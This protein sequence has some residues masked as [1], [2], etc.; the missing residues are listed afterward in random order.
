MNEDF[1]RPEEIPFQEVLDALQDEDNPIKPRYLYRLTDLGRQ[2]QAKISALWD[3]LP[4]WRRSGLLEDLEFLFEKNTLLSFEAICRLAI[5]DQEAEIRFLA[6][7]SLD[8]YDVPDL[9]DTFIQMMETDPDTDVRAMSA[10]ALGKYV[11][12][13]EVED[14]PAATFHRLEERLLTTQNGQDDDLIRRRALEALGFSSRPEVAERI[15]LAFASQDHDWMQSALFAMGRSYDERW[16][17][18]VLSM[19]TDRMPTIRAE[20]ARAAGEL[21]MS[22]AAQHLIELTDDVDDEVRSAAIW[23][24]SQIGGKTANRVLK[25]LLAKSD[26]EEDVELITTAIDNLILNEEIGL[27]GILELPDND[28]FDFDED[29]LGDDDLDDGDLDDGDLDDDDL[30]DDDLDDDDLDE[31]DQAFDFDEFDDED[32]LN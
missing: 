1:T 23:S 27:R 9:I 31:D 21:E 13:G 11:F 6:I 8:E 3:S 10:S 32:E 20:A 5:S 28:D 14:L 2:E 7:R 25:E 15:E 16:H 29:D 24:L 26:T 19:L 18:S 30:D 12:M 22:S 4:I 17:D